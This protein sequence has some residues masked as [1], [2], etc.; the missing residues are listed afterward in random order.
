MISWWEGVAR[1]FQVIEDEAKVSLE[2][3][4]RG[5]DGLG[6]GADEADGEAPEPRGVLRAV[7]GTDTASVFVEC[8]VEDVVGEF[9]APVA[10]IECEE[11]LGGDGVGGVAG[12]A[13]GALDTAFAG[14]FL[15]DGALDLE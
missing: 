12:D 13:V 11:A 9:D 14:G 1:Q 4:Q 8:G 6:F 3:S 15:D 7:A 10:A 5:G 2:F